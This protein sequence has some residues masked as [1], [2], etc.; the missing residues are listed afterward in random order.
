ML[1]MLGYGSL[2]EDGYFDH[3]TETALQQFESDQQLKVDGVYSNEDHDQLIVQVLL[4][5]SE[6][7]VTYQK[8]LDSLE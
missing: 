8:M 6:H 5:L 7:D 3:A 4:Y 1:N 2:R